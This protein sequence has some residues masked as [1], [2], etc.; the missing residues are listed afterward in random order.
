MNMKKE[1]LQDIQAEARAEVSA[2][3]KNRHF[4]NREETQEEI[5]QR[6]N[7]AAFHIQDQSAM[8]PRVASIQR[9]PQSQWKSY[10]KTTKRTHQTSRRDAEFE[11]DL[12]W[13][14]GSTI[15]KPETTN[16]PLEFKPEMPK[17]DLSK[18]QAYTS[19]DPG[20]TQTIPLLVKPE[21][22]MKFGDLSKLHAYES[23]NPGVAPP[24][25]IPLDQSQLKAAAHRRARL[26][27]LNQFRHPS[28]HE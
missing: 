27:A 24:P 28:K 15:R 20:A 12:D 9:R 11:D 23:L 22:P 16:V 5:I 21:M 6:Q 13:G 25:V 14:S 2:M 18:L 17:L 8:S 26:E 4:P 10:R 3:N 7:A 1:D 19:V